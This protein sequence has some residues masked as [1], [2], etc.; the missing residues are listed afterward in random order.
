MRFHRRPARRNT[1]SELLQLDHVDSIAE[2]E[3]SGQAL[4]LD[5]RL[6]L[7]DFAPISL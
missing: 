1:A 2:R 5:F 3:G 7:P 4:K 6:R